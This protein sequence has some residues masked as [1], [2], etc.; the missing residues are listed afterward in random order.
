MSKLIPILAC[1]ALIGCA[2]SE[3]VTLRGDGH[4]TSY[5]N[6]NNSTGDESLAA[7]LADGTRRDVTHVRLNADTTRWMNQGTGVAESIPTASITRFESTTRT[8]PAIL[9]GSLG[10][11]GGG[12]LGM[13]TGVAGTG[14]GDTK[15]LLQG[16]SGA[17]GAGIG[18]IAGS[19]IGAIHGATINHTLLPDSSQLPSP[20]TGQHVNGR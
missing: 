4:S 17:V 12:L 9:G 8:F 2:S 18:L 5:V 15:A 3:T 11:L 19:V 7:V 10:L 16:V 6:F 13:V 1:A 14:H 20:A